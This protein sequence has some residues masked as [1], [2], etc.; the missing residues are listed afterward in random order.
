MAHVIISI[1]QHVKVSISECF[2]SILTSSRRGGAQRAVHIYQPVS[3]LTEISEHEKRG[4]FTHM[5]HDG[6]TTEKNRNIEQELIF[7]GIVSAPR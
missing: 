6:E 2:Q 1:S 3:R 5:F 7:Y 4:Q